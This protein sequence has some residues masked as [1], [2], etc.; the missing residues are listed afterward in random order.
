M[1]SCTDREISL[2]FLQLP[3]LSCC[4]KH[5]ECCVSSSLQGLCDTVARLYTSVSE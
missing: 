5:S 1:D 4:T 2:H 3:Q